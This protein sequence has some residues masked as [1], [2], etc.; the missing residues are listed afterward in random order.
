MGAARKAVVLARRSAATRGVL[1]GNSFWLLVAK[2]LSPGLALRRNA[3]N[4]GLFGG[5][6]GWMALLGLI[7]LKRVMQAANRRDERILATEVLRAGQFVRVESI[8][9]PTKR[10]RRAA[11]RQRS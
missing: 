7:G 4:K 10:E 2:L 8:P 3:I 1:S 9:K 6:G 11:K 5:H